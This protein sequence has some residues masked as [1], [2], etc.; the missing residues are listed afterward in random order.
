MILKD[1]IT[2]EVH[3]PTT[4]EMTWD[5]LTA[6]A[7]LEAWFGS[8]VRL[9]ARLGGEFRETWSQAGR[10]IVTQ[11]RVT[12]FRPPTAIAWTWADEDWSQTTLL[13]FTIRPGEA[14]VVQL[15]HSGWSKFDASLGE[16][17]RAAHEAGWRGHLES[18]KRYAAER[19]RSD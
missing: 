4:P 14:S 18:L 16:Q 5:L 15:N 12:D 3:L 9:D 10:K 17:L 2:L 6:P 7:H 11:G 1:A 13:T 8:H 19:V